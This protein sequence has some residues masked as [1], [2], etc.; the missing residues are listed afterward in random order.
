MTEEKHY[1]LI[2]MDV[3][4]P[5]LDGLA[6]TKIIRKRGGKQPVIIALTANAIKEDMEECLNIGMDDYVSK[7]TTIQN[8]IAVIKKWAINIKAV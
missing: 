5:E 2:L 7:P 3:Q 6:T 4:M 8:L 1:D